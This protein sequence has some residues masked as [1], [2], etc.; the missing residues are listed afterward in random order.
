MIYS[1]GWVT[2]FSSS[3][4]FLTLGQTA[5][6]SDRV[7]W[8]R[9]RHVNAAWTSSN[10]WGAEPNSV[11]F[12]RHLNADMGSFHSV[13]SRKCFTWKTQ[14]RPME[15]A[16]HNPPSTCIDPIVGS[17][18]FRWRSVPKMQRNF[19]CYNL[20]RLG[21]RSGVFP[22]HVPCNC[23]CISYPHEGVYGRDQAALSSISVSCK[24]SH[25]ATL[26]WVSSP[27]RPS[28]WMVDI[29]IWEVDWYARK[30]TYELQNWYVDDLL[31]FS[32]LF[33]K[34]TFFF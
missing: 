32:Y 27:V 34:W 31:F 33:T 14:G 30:D 1:V 22:N 17:P 6:W 4:P 21:R 7:P 8:C 29:P 20:A 12:V 25:G 19:K 11:R 9:C 5:P 15:D 2:S 24:S 26:V 28:P 16:R 23:N 13:K 10:G 18:W 3:S